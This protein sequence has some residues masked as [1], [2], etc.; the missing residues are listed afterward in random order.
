MQLKVIWDA[1]KVTL[2]A[3]LLAINE[4]KEAKHNRLLEEHQFSKM[5][6]NLMEMSEFQSY[7]QKGRLLKLFS[8]IKSNDAP[9]RKPDRLLGHVPRMH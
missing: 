3:T 5:D 7:F 4:Q 1:A 2:G 8:P 6:M 9:S